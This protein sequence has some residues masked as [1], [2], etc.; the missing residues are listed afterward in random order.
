MVMRFPS[1]N[2]ATS[3]PSLTARR[4]KVDSAMSE[5]RQNSVI[6]ARTWS[7]FIGIGVGQRWA[8]RFGPP[9]LA[10]VAHPWKGSRAIWSRSHLPLY[11]AENRYF[12]ARMFRSYCVAALIL[13][14]SMG[15]GRAGYLDENP[16]EVFESV[17]ARIGAL[18]VQAARDPFIWLRLQEL[19]REPCDQKSI[20]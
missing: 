16:D 11:N 13:A 12:G 5:R 18:P 2:R 20:N 17:Y 10:P 8:A 14:A 9:V 4:P 6:S 1:R 15:M 19:K 3:L 7:F